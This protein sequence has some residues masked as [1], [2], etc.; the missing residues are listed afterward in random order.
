MYFQ[1]R[2]TGDFYEDTEAKEEIKKRLLYLAY[3]AGGD[4]KETYQRNASFLD[5]CNICSCEQIDYFYDENISTTRLSFIEDDDKLWYVGS[6]GGK[7][8]INVLS[9][10]KRVFSLKQDNNYLES[11][12]AADFNKYLLANEVDLDPE[13]LELLDRVSSLSY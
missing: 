8:F 3:K 4:W 5:A 6:W 12:F 13:F 9:W 7:M 10:I 2:K 1:K 11:L